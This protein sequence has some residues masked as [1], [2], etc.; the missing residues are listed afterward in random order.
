[1]STF[2]R[3][4]WGALLGA[5]FVFIAVWLGSLAALLVAAGGIAGYLV[6]AVLEGEIK[7]TQE[8]RGSRIGPR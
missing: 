7:V 4:Q 5:L 3:K 8:R 1:M 6:G 2:D